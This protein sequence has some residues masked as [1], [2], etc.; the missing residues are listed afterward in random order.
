MTDYPKLKV[1]D[2]KA[3]L[4]K[5][6]L[7][8]TGLKQALV[9]RLQSDDVA[10]TTQP[11][12]ESQTA[13]DAT[14]PIAESQMSALGESGEDEFTQPI[15][16]SLDPTAAEQPLSKDGPALVPDS[17]ELVGDVPVSFQGAEKT[18]A[19]E[20]LQMVD[21]PTETASSGPQTRVPPSE[22]PLP[23]V[24][25]R[26]DD[27]T[28]NNHSSHPVDASPIPFTPE[29]QSQVPPIVS[30]QTS[31]APEEV[32][33][34]TRKRKRRS[35]TPPP[36]AESIAL[37]RAKHKAEDTLDPKDETLS[38]PNGA[39]LRT[40]EAITTGE[41][42]IDQ[43]R[44]WSTP[45]EEIDVT[46]DDRT[47]RP[48]PSQIEHNPSNED[49]GSELGQ[50]SQDAGVTTEKPVE[51][52]GYGG[53]QSVRVNGLQEP[54][55]SPSSNQP[56]TSKETASVHK[57]GRFKELFSGPAKKEQEISQQASASFIETE[58]DDRSVEPAL[59]AAT[60]ALYIRDFMRPLHQPTLKEHLLS[61]ATPPKSSPNPHM[62]N[63]F[64]LD[65]IK[66]HC[67]VSFNNVSAASR[68]RSAIH[69]RVWPD[70]RTRKPLWADFIPEEKVDEWIETERAPSGAS[71][72]RSGPAKRWEVV[73]IPSSDGERG[74]GAIDAVLREV[75]SG[76]AGI[77][78]GGGRGVEGAPLGPRLTQNESNGLKSQQQAANPASGSNAANSGFVALD[79]LFKSTTAK[80]KLYYL[81]VSKGTVDRRIDQL[82]DKRPFEDRGAAMGRSY[83]DLR[84]YTFED[85]HHLIDRGPD[86]NVGY[87]GGMGRGR[88]RGNFSGRGGWRENSWRDRRDRW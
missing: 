19:N 31:I 26:E 10:S 48:E 27:L 70:E 23:E 85:G 64:Y 84:R 67:L 80:P 50:P 29:S 12:T 37:K 78:A 72:G 46:A 52:I 11:E 18:K 68:V 49:R 43:A 35:I 7:P 1:V 22:E 44:D 45:Q 6:G 17:S 25:P 56:S 79:S 40:A 62:M 21:A 53:E 42:V 66:T 60:S 88:G 20:D 65:P 13:S 14:L 39:N 2:L 75:G 55:R 5:R 59:H 30:N 47:D 82:N 8:Q 61:L 54:H 36:T 32:A 81:P 33:E 24:P 3:E 51:E 73:Y 87:R 63:N 4:K 15:P 34:D 69:N 57:D 71:S 38:E 83:G 41:K 77:G 74:E 9:E 76:S 16:P 86:V 28:L 58:D